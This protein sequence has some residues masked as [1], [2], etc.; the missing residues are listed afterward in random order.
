MRRRA[1]IVAAALGLLA[2]SVL[3][4]S[5]AGANSTATAPIHYNDDACGDGTAKVV[6]TASFSAKSG[7]VTVRVKMHGMLPGS[8][9]LLLWHNTTSPCDQLADL[10]RFKVDASG[11]GEKAGTASLQGYKR[12]FA[13]VRPVG[14]SPISDSN[15]DEVNLG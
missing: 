12:V 9:R 13:I 7:M 11:D 14:D 5:Q 8:Y 3:G 6:G 4:I 2:V 10:G 1:I 15:S